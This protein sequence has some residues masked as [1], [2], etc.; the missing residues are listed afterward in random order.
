[1]SFYFE[2]PSQSQR[3]EK[4]I[5]FPIEEQ[6]KNVETRRQVVDQLTAQLEDVRRMVRNGFTKE[7]FQAYQQYEKSLGAAIR[8]IKN[9][10][11]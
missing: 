5:S 9:F 11:K 4:G 2:N 7:R 1:M 3:E 8:L 10:R 6:L